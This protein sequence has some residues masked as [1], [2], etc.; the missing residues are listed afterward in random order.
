MIL[1]LNDNACIVLKRSRLTED[2]SRESK[3]LQD[4]I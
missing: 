1:A 4:S 2:I 3:K